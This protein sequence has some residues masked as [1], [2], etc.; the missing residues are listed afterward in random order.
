MTNVG[1]VISQ[2][3]YF[4][5]SEDFS[6]LWPQFIANKSRY[7]NSPIDT[8]PDIPKCTYRQEKIHLEW[9]VFISSSEH[10]SFKKEKG[11]I[12]VCSFFLQSVKPPI[13]MLLMLLMSGLVFISL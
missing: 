1:S 7:N 10:F 9:K 4:L 3:I 2:L 12:G 13:F 6:S 5:Q 8:R 11:E